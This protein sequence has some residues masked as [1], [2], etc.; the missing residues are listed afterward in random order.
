MLQVPYEAD[1]N[2]LDCESVSKESIDG[3]LRSVKEYHGRLLNDFHVAQEFR[4]QLQQEQELE[5]VLDK[6]R[7]Y[8]GQQG[9]LSF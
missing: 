1:K 6:S 4:S 2:Y 5:N 7:Q 9:T 3:V 8:L